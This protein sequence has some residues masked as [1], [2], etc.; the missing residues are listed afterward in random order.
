MTVTFVSIGMNQSVGFFKIFIA[1][2]GGA[3]AVL[4]APV[5]TS[6]VAAGNLWRWNCYWN[7]ETRCA[8][9]NWQHRSDFRCQHFAALCKDERTSTLIT[10][11]DGWLH[12]YGTVHLLFD[13]VHTR[14]NSQS[15]RHSH[16]SVLMMRVG[17][18]NTSAHCG[19]LAFCRSLLLNPFFPSFHT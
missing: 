17:G 18:R 5:H 16:P 4:R 12:Q 13:G 8:L 3:C 15:I 6:A 7:N 10:Y 19:F 2:R 1:D 11:F 9:R 14:M